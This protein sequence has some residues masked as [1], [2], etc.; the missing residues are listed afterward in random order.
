MAKDVAC[1][2]G[3]TVSISGSLSGDMNFT[4]TGGTSGMLTNTPT[5]CS[6][7]GTNLVMNGNPSLAFNSVINFFYGGPSSFT[8][9]ETGPITY[10]PNPTG[11]CQ[12]NLTITA[13]I[14]GDAEHTLLSCTLAGTACGQTI[15]QSCE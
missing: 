3:G 12:T 5:N 10:G 4:A 14:E 8:V 7:P 2:G 15:S 1:S 6:I 13:S 11:V 9:T